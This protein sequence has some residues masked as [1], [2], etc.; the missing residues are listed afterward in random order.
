MTSD[1]K[2]RQT[3][4]ALLVASGWCVCNVADGMR[5]GYHPSTVHGVE[6]EVDNN[7]KG[8]QTLRQAMLTKAFSATASE[9]NRCFLHHF[10]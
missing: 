4:D 6:A 1:A 7:L 10:R 2:A 5:A 8:A 9:T 3:I